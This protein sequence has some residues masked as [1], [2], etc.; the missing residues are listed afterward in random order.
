MKKTDKGR[1]FRAENWAVAVWSRDDP[2][3]GVVHNELNVIEQ[4]KTTTNK[5]MMK[6]EWHMIDVWSKQAK[7]KWRDDKQ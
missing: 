1:T 2:I 7:F 4:M 6:D 3:E 5:V